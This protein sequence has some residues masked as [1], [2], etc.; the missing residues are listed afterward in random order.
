MGISIEDFSGLV[1]A[2]IKDE[3]KTAAPDID[4]VDAVNEVTTMFKKRPM[5]NITTISEFITF[6]TNNVHHWLNDNKK[7]QQ[8]ISMIRSYCN[9]DITVPEY[10]S[11]H[12][13]KKMLMDRFP[14]MSVQINHVCVIPLEWMNEANHNIYSVR[15]VPK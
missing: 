1:K 8:D 3:I 6:I 9:F 12:Y 5:Y 14:Y 4:Y 2:A 10:F 11:Q 13:I 15:L 7:V